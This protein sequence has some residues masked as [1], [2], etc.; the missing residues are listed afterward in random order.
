M[1]KMIKVVTSLCYK[2]SGVSLKTHFTVSSEFN[3]TYQNL[4]V[5]VCVFKTA[6]KTKNKGKS[7]EVFCS[8][9]NSSVNKNIFEVTNHPL[10]LLSLVF[11]LSNS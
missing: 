5:I 2:S 10:G 8:N 1:Y 3:F 7:I 4:N 9:S 6:L 11:Y